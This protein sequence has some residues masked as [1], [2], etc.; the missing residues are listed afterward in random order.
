M[1]VLAFLWLLSVFTLHPSQ[2]SPGDAQAWFTKARELYEKQ[3]WLKSEEAANKALTIDPTLAEAEI[4]LGLIS[5]TRR[6]F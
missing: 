5:T 3:E 4:L 6:Q 2:N 1:K